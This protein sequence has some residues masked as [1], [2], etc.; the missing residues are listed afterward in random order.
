MNY[1]SRVDANINGPL[2]I[3]QSVISSQLKKIKNKKFLT[4]NAN[5]CSVCFGKHFKSQ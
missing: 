5:T 3:P 2:A 1:G 4:A